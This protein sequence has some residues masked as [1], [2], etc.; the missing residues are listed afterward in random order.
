M[1]QYQLILA[2]LQGLFEWWPI[3]SSGVVLL[4]SIYFGF[5]VNVGYSISLALH[6]PSG[7]AILIL[8]WG[9]F[10]D[11]VSNMAR[12][13]LGGFEK[14]YL[15]GLTAS[16][17]I[18]YLLYILFVNISIIY[19]LTA[20]LIVSI[21]LFIT[22]IALLTSSRRVRGKASRDISFYDWFITGILQGLAVLPGFSRSGLTMG[23]LSLRKYDPSLVVRTSLLLGAPAL[24]LAGSYN[25]LRIIN[26]ID[27]LTLAIAY[28]IVFITSILSAKLLIELAKRIKIYYFTL[29]LALLILLNI[30]LELII[31]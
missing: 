27:P 28:I 20:L 23:Y 10:R 30:I 1:D 26:V 8:Y 16:L 31:S 6:L 21:G 19:G 3:S 25:L 17:I 13:K 12:F 11:V 4:T 9:R 5:P 24:I 2:L 15:S 22:S 29:L 18:G 7:L 14:G